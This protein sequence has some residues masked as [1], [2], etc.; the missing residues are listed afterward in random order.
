ML[1]AEHIGFVG[2]PSTTYPLF[3]QLAKYASDTVLVQLT[4]HGNPKMRVYSMW[5][6]IQRNKRLATLLFERIKY[7]S[8][9]V[10]YHSGCIICP[11][12]VSMLVDGRLYASERRFA[13]RL[14]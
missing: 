8:A 9:Y 1:E 10:T 6:L 2:E 11:I 13:P 14:Y 12:P 7:D 5:A 4:Y 3:E